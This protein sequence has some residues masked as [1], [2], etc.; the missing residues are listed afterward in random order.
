[1]SQ[2]GFSLDVGE[3]LDKEDKY[4]EQVLKEMRESEIPPEKSKKP[5]TSEKQSE[6]S[7]EEKHKNL[8]NSQ[9]EKNVDTPHKSSDAKTPKKEPV[10]KKVPKKSEIIVKPLKEEKT[11]EKE[12]PKQKE[13]RVDPQQSSRSGFKKLVLFLIIVCAAM[14]LYY[15]F[16][17]LPPLFAPTGA[18]TSPTI[19]STT[20]DLTETPPD[21]PAAPSTSLPDRDSSD[22]LSDS[23]D[24]DIRDLL[25]GKLGA[26]PDDAA[27]A[28]NQ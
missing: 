18:A 7:A 4:K 22:T 2:Y 19:E 8:K 9:K 12:V 27:N 10:T 21:E 11:V 25:V 3:D 15:G 23:V 24:D 1:M 6:E 14:V 26:S 20:P 13:R 17:V 16:Q 28:T 5:K